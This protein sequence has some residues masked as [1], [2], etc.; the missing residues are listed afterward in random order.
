MSGLEIFSIK[1]RTPTLLGNT[2]GNMSL[3]S[4]LT[5][6]LTVTN[7]ATF[8]RPGD[9]RGYVPVIPNVPPSLT[10][11]GD[12]V[13]PG[14]S[15]WIP[16][17]FKYPVEVGGYVIV[18]GD[19]LIFGDLTVENLTVNGVSNLREDVTMG[20]AINNV[21]LDVNGNSIIT[22]VAAFVGS[23]LSVLNNTAA[24]IT[25]QTTSAGAS[26]KALEAEGQVDVTGSAATAPTF[27]VTGSVDG[28]VPLVAFEV[29]SNAAGTCFRSVGNSDIS[30][31]IPQSR[32]ADDKGAMAYPE[33]NLSNVATTMN[34]ATVA[35]WPDSTIYVFD[36]DPG[37]PITLQ[38]QPPRY[39]GRFIQILNRSGQNIATVNNADG[40][41]IAGQVA[42]ANNQSGMWLSTGTGNTDW[43]TLG[44]FV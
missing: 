24:G 3:S 35:T 37:G 20:T 16:A 36:N 40:A 18:A 30:G 27:E 33:A 22:S 42:I 2:S 11:A 4:V 1:N 26:G 32:Y 13:N 25:L 21:T 44:S 31:D 8:G 38:L 29:P 7:G 12:I 9:Q 19:V 10:Y 43:I 28:G 17:F 34:L 5:N 14:F 41:G 39:A 23:T 6:L 15:C